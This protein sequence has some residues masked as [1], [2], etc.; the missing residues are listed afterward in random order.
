MPKT[1]PHAD[2]TSQLGQLSRLMELSGMT[3]AELERRVGLNRSTVGRM[4]SGE[5]NMR[6]D[7]AEAIARECG[8]KVG[9]IILD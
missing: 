3:A 7:H 2:I 5:S 6:L 1:K 4:L 9:F 8:A